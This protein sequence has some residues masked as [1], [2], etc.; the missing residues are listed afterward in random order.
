MFRR[1][2]SGIFPTPRV[3]FLTI[4]G[5]LC[6]LA[7]SVPAAAAPSTRC[8]GS[9]AADLR[10][11][12]GTGRSGREIPRTRPRLRPLPDAERD[13][14]RAGPG[15]PRSAAAGRRPQPVPSTTPPPAVV[16]MRL[17]GADPTRRSRG[18]MPSPGR[19]HYLIGE[20]LALAAGRADLRPGP[21][22]RRLPGRQPRLLRHRAADR[23]RLRRRAGRR[24]GRRGAG[25]RRRAQGLRLDDGGDLVHGHRGRRASAA[26]SR[27]LPGGVGRASARSRAGTCSRATACASAWPSFDARHPLVIDPVLGYSTYLG[28]SSNDEGFGIA[29]D[30]AGNAYV[31]GT[32]IS[33][34]FPVSSTSL[35]PA[36]AGV[37]DAFVAKLDPTGTTLLYSTYLGG[38]GDDSG[39]AIAVDATGNAYVTGSTTSSNFPVLSA[40]QTTFRGL[41]DA[42][43]AKL[44]PTGGALLYST[45][46]GGND[47]DFAF[48][49]A[50]D[51]GR[52]RVRD[53]LHRLQRVS[54]QRRVHLSGHQEHRERRVRR[55]GRPRRAPHSATA[56]SSAA[57]ATTSGRQSPPT[58]AAP[59]GSSAPPPPPTSNPRARSSPRSAGQ[60]DAF[61]GR[62]DVAGDVVYLTYL[63]GQRRRRGLRR[64]GGHGGQ[65]LRDRRRPR[66]RTSRWPAR[67]SPRSPAATTPSS[68]S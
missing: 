7:S 13:R 60:T 25:L 50:V 32:T 47:Q 12:P 42:F 19:S 55:Q 4:L 38:S 66:R 64:R 53:G 61:V 41:S 27:H 59:C 43:V 52:Q 1:I 5:L 20:R 46:L 45:L 65:R 67:C 2:R 44:D 39:N 8:R 56:G 37:T 54:E 11:Q 30:S 3:R 35:Q 18:S 40:F 51:A 23:V 24:S 29:V 15:R 14:L 9:A 31:T 17:V 34:D 49:I 26:A 62:L 36:R 63:G 10:A 68:P 28:G 33:S 58:P 57:P 16:R 21:L 6:L 22:R 48:G